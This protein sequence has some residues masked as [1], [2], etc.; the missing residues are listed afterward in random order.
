MTNVKG[1]L[2]D[3]EIAALCNSS[4]PM[5]EPYTPSLVRVTDYE[6][7]DR[8]VI[9]YGQSSY[10]YDMRLSAKDF[11]I[12]KHQ[13][14]K[15]VD[16]KNFDERFLEKAELYDDDMGSQ[17]FIV[18]AHS[19]GLGVTIERLDIPKD[20]TA[21]FIGK[22]TY[23]RCGLIANLT[24]GEAGW[25]GHLTLEFSNS[26]SADM[27]IYANEGCIQAL[28]FRAESCS[29]DYDTRQ[30]KYQNQAAEVTLARL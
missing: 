28:F 2:S 15:I 20:V 12:F 27:C 6:G 16:P 8:K 5:I 30:G 26:S 14:G 19:Y 17:Y 21:M 24:P 23:A 10:G 25:C 18:P 11:R 29:V 1:L 3:I 22:S 4:N 13:P 9:S 7:F